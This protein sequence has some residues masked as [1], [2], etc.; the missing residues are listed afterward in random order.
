MSRGKSTTSTI[1][2]VKS[3]YASWVPGRSLKRSE[4]MRGSV[5]IPESGAEPVQPIGQ[6]LL[7]YKHKQS[8]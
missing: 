5:N 2:T 3:L 1:G 8:N 7:Q 4:S 6:P